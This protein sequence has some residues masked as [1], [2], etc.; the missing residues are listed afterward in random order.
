MVTSLSF[1]VVAILVSCSALQEPVKVSSSAVTEVKSKACP[2]N[3][4]L[5]IRREDLKNEVGIILQ[6]L[7]PTPCGD[8]GWTR[9]AHLDMNDPSQQ[10]PSEWNLITSPVRGCN[11]GST[12]PSCNSATFTSSLPSYS[13]VCGRV[14]AYHSGAP[15][16][17][18][19]SVTGSNPGLD[20]FYM[21]GVSITHGAPTQRQHIWSFAVSHYETDTNYDGRWNCAC[22]N[23]NFNWPYQLPSFVG[24]NYFCDTG[25]PGP[26]TSDSTVYADDPLWDGAGCGPSSACCEFNTP[27]WFHTML[28]QPIS[29]DLEV[30]ICANAASSREDVIV[31]IIDI[32]AM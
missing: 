6:D 2:S 12:V 20:G 9:I 28:P 32:F 17:F 1:F 18:G 31:S 24:N 19:P 8:T 14:I 25:N 30:R 3:E 15:E 10:C 16:A 26:G 29:D 21:D 4:S 5:S 11:R 27:P 13:R 23:T 22:T 7:F